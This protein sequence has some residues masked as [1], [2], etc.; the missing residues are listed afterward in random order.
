[1]RVS[2][3]VREIN[4]GA[5][6]GFEVRGAR[7]TFATDQVIMALPWYTLDRIKVTGPDR[8]G[9]IF[10]ELVERAQELESSPITGL[11]T[12]WDLPWLDN[13]HATLVG[14]L[15]QWVFPKTGSQTLGAQE[16]PENPNEDGSNEPSQHYYQ[17]VISASRDLSGIP[18]H[19][20]P[21]V[22]HEDL[23]HVF[24]VVREKAK[25][26]ACEPV[27]DPHSVFS[28]R[29][30]ASKLRPGTDSG[31]QGLWVAGDWTQTGWP[32]TMESAIL[33]GFEAARAIEEWSHHDDY[34]RSQDLPCNVTF[35]SSPHTL[36]ALFVPPPPPSPCMPSP[37]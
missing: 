32:A 23:A 10:C 15:C 27:T 14:R 34:P 5:D 17:I 2:E 11:H 31:I 16:L 4:R 9:Q 37:S 33:S 28:V 13:P 35:L 7:E 12:W 8:A 19:Q 29:A 36:S 30:G 20:L 6:G 1:V 24:P 21:E 25:L 3:R 22:I 26:L 18:K